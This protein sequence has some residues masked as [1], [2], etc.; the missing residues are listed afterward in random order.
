VLQA[1][2]CAPIPSPF[3][4]F[5]FGF[6]TESIKELGDVSI[7]KVT[8]IWCDNSNSIKIINNPIFHAQTKHIEVH[9]HFIREKMLIG[10]IKLN[11][12]PIS[13]QVVNICTKP[14]GKQKNSCFKKLLVYV[15]FNKSK[16]KRKSSRPKIENMYPSNLI[17]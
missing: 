3:A 13:D 11:H 8:Q 5:F 16:V 14:L 2:E 9:Y 4:V 17:Y 7:R 1:K 6:A 10:E 15:V 12:I